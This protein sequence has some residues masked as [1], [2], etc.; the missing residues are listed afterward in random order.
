MPRVKSWAPWARSALEQTRGVQAIAIDT[1]TTGLAFHDEPFCATL[2]W[3][4]PAK[5]Y[6]FDEIRGRLQSAYFELKDP[7]GDLWLSNAHALQTILA[8]TPV[9]IFHNAKFDLQKLVLAHII[10]P[11]EIAQHQIEDTQTI[12]TLLDENDRHG[13]KHLARVYLGEE[14][15]EEAVLRKVRRKLG[16][17]KADGFHHI[18]REH[19]IPYALK[20]TEFTYRLWEMGKR[21]LELQ[22]DALQALY[23]REMELT[24]VL[25]RMEANGIGLDLD[26]LQS[27]LAE[28]EERVMEGWITITQLAGNADLNPQSPTQL[29][30]AFE[31]RGIFLDSTDVASLRNL[32]DELAKAIL[33]YRSDK[34][35]HTTYLKGLLDEQVDGVVHPSFNLNGARTGRMSSGGAFNN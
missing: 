34:K 6:R 1:E 30:A 9:W 10:T 19:I 28:Y 21:R 5:E 22:D 26:Y 17:K 29:K 24:K 32:D 11:T 33:D 27:T 16:L 12:W 8:R 35:I 18:P 23:R 20:D 4:Q 13:L 2:T 14:T 15:N 25:L 7:A 31:N 3:R